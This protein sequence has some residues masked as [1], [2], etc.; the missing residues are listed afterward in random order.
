MVTRLFFVLLSVS[1]LLGCVGYARLYPVRGPLS[2]QTPM[3][4]VQVKLTGVINS[5]SL[6]FHTPDGE[7]FKG[8]WTM[9]RPVKT[10][11]GMTAGSNSPLNDMPS[12]WDT[13]YGEDYYMSH[14]LGSTLYGAST[15]KGTRGTIVNVEFYAVRV[16]ENHLDRFGVAKDSSGN[17]YKM[18]FPT[19]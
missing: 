8:Q 2:A 14:V 9:V 11:H 15:I 3:P 12:A 4:I 5:G 1:L 6:S 17:I 7:I 13:V 19:F 18:A 10:P 16:S